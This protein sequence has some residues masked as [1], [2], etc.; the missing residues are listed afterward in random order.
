[1]GQERQIESELQ[2]LQEDLK[3]L[4]EVLAS[5]DQS[6]RE[7]DELLSEKSHRLRLKEE[8]LGTY[9]EH[10]A[11][12]RRNLKPTPA[13]A[14]FLTAGIAAT[15]MGLLEALEQQRNECLGFL[16]GLGYE[17]DLVRCVVA[18]ADRATELKHERDSLKAKA[19]A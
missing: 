11:Q 4:E 15:R 18:L 2:R 6:L 16:S 10:L 8:D 5:R 12:T 3:R 1:M 14:P 17:G 19:Q 9:M 7:K 13:E